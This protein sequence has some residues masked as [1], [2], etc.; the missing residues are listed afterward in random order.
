VEKFRNFT[1]IFEALE[2]KS[3]EYILVGGVAVI[4]HGLPCATEVVDIF[5]NMN[6]PNVT[7]LREALM[8][9]YDD[10]YI[11]EI[12][13]EELERYPVIRYGTPEGFYIDILTRLGEAVTYH[14]LDVERLDVNG[15]TIR[16][17]SPKALYNLKKDSVRPKDQQDALFLK[18]LI[19]QR[20]LQKE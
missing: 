10:P 1:R 17:A 8:S 5:I 9:I 4:F 6:R 7:K 19:E 13:F 2:V 12:S 3:V 18:A 16:I 20:R 15:V 11:D 14:D